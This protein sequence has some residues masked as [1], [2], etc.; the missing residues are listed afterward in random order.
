MKR[1]RLVAFIFV[2]GVLG[3]SIHFGWLPDFINYAGEQ[4][5]HQAPDSGQQ[6]L[7][8]AFAN[9]QSNLQ[10]QVTAPVSRILP[11]D[12][13]GSR[14]QRFILKLAN[15]QTVLVAHNIDL[16]P[17]LSGIAVG[18]SVTV[19]GEYEWNTQG[20]VIH[21]THHDPSGSRLGGWIEFRGNRYQ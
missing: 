16:A 18:D 12:D 14:H 21:W 17:R 10:V 2:L 1:H 5:Q 9:E 15:G 6:Q 4:I 7:I 3:A 19:A 13:Q 20:G 8:N 11:D